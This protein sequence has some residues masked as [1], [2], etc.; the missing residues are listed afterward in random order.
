MF[1]GV[2]ASLLFI[3]KNAKAATINAQTCSTVDVQSAISIAQNGDTV[4][5]PSGTCTWS[6]SITI[7]KGVKLFGSGAGGYVGRSTTSRSIGL[8]NK[9]FTTSTGLDFVN[10]ETLTVRYINR[11]GEN[12]MTGTV[13]SYA[14]SSLTLNITSL[15]GSGTFSVWIIERPSTTKIVNSAVTQYGQAMWT[16]QENTAH[17]IHIGGIHFDTGTGSYGNHINILGSSNGKPVLIYNNWFSQTGSMGGGILSDVNR[18]VVYRNS[19]NAT[20]CSASFV[21]CDLQV[22]GAVGVKNIYLE[23]SW[24]TPST[25]GDDDTSGTSNFYVEDNYFLAFWQAL[26][27]TDGAGRAVIRHN[28]FDNS[29]LGSHGADT[30]DLGV[31]HY[32]V[33]DNEFIYSD[34]GADTY[35]I[36]YWFYIRGGTGTIHNNVLPNIL[37]S[38][39]GDKSEISMTVMNLSRNSGPNPCWG[40]NLGGVQYPAP[41]QVGMGYVTGLAEND[42]ITYRGDSEPLYIWGNDGNYVVDVY[43]YGGSECVNPDSST[44]YIVHGRDY[45]NN[46]TPKPQYTEY[47]YPHPLT[48]DFETEDDASSP[49]RSAGSPSGVQSIGT[50]QIAISLSTNESST[51]KYG[52][53]SSTSYASISNTFSTTG[54]TTHSQTING[55]TNGST[56]NYYVR[57]RDAALNANTNDYTISFTVASAP[58]VVSGGG[59]GAGGGSTSGSSNPSTT[60]AFTNIKLVTEGSTYFVIVNNKRYGVTNPGILFSYGLEFNDARP[61]TQSENTLP[62]TETLKPGDGA[63]VKKPND[64]TVYLIFDNSK[65]GFI[66]ES[67]FNSLSYKFSNV[68]E[69]TAN[70]LDALSIG[71]VVSDLNM[72]HPNGTFVNQDGTI[73]RVS[74]GKKYGIPNMEVY[75]TYTIDNS[76]KYVVPANS[77]DR[78][79]PLGGVLEKRLVG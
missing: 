22:N 78:S 42:S 33:Y 3:S 62:Y 73:F 72:A 24:T 9:T 71:S 25:M 46:E 70:E 39:W 32:E 40:A 12:Y 77:K 34:I 68:L 41:R 45:F 7:S 10:G 75:N 61:Q 49:I 52:T 20:L 19:F 29:V 16:I 27:V 43:N 31:R 23:S 76:F 44:D 60:L 11:D 64:S 28:I 35:N 6:T 21:G 14:G 37:S 66:S 50:T 13:S 4:L 74:E 18:G 56:H 58:E 5:I 67:V 2:A 36:N 54:G 38:T 53:V 57:C 79:L 15:G 65:H 55:L 47:T 26:G 17:S 63:L 48:V 69:V 30:E 8:G 59:G 1:I 51:C